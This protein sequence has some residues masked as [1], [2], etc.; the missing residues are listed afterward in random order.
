MINVR[1]RMNTSFNGARLAALRGQVADIVGR[2]Q[3]RDAGRAQW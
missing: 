1:R 2:V 3:L